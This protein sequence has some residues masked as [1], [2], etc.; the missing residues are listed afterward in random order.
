MVMSIAFHPSIGDLYKK[1][2]KINVK[3]F[4]QKQVIECKCAK[5]TSGQRHENALWKV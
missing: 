1:L 4:I 5:A 3:I 2:Y